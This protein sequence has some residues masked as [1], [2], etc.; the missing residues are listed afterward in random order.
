MKRRFFTPGLI[1]VAPQW[2]CT[3]GALRVVGAVAPDPAVPAHDPPLEPR[4]EAVFLLTA[5]AEIEHALM[6]QYL[7]AA[8]SVRVPADGPN[9]DQLG[10]VQASL[11]QIAREEM[12]HLATVQ[13]LLHLVGGPLNFNREHSPYA[14]EIYPFRFKLEPLTL[15]SLAKYVSAESPLHVPGD[16]PEDDKTLL[17]QISKD[18]TRSNDGHDVHHVGPIFARL[19]HL[20]EVV[21]SDDDFRLDTFGWQAKFQDWGFQPASPE[22]GEALIIDSFPSS[23]VNQVRAAA[24]TAVQK[25]AA[26]GEGFDTA[27]AGPTGSESHFERFFDI[28]KRVWQL[29]T[30]GVVITWPVAENPNTTSSPSEAPGLADMVA[31]VQEAQAS[32]GRINYPRARAWAQLFNLRYRMLLARLSHFLRLDQNLYLDAPDAQLGDRTARG[33]LLMWTFD[34]M[35]HLAKI[36]TKLVQLPKDDPPGQLHAGPPFELPYTLNL[37]D[38]EPQRWR[39]HLDISQAVVRL[40]REKLQPDNQVQDRDGFLDDLVRLDEQAQTVMRALAKGQSIPQES[41]PRNFQKVVRILEDAIRGFSIGQHGNFWAGKTRDQFINTKVFGDRLVELNLDGSI[42]RDP[43]VAHLVRRLQGTEPPPK[44]QMPLFRPPAPTERTRFIREWISQGCPDNDPP[45]QVGLNHER[46]P[47]P[48]PLSPPPP[49]SPT[50]P[51]SFEADIKSLFRENPDRVA[52]R[53]IAGFDLHRYEDVRDHADAILARLEDGSMPCDGSWSP[54]RIA[55]FR[56][57]IEDGKQP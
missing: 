40:I 54:D 28:Y 53:A 30:A 52:M 27:P 57:W 55:L 42:N 5:A 44:Q 6:V 7:Y 48:E 50:T 32:K 38:R 19:A 37:P 39:T 4:D 22:T 11:T 56:K 14:S 41:L 36:A 34:E 17:V 21:L 3:D 10:Q 8:Y 29:S 31:M 20:F 47:A 15:D 43:E 9:S 33:L 12:G 2:E 45:G 46:D 26:Q 13:N 16:L 51:L 1:A 18:A 49:P 23:D 24:V 35:R 25:I